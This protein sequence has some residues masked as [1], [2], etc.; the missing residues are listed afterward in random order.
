MS[1]ASASSPRIAVHSLPFRTDFRGTTNIRDNFV[2]AA[3]N[4]GVLVAH[5]RGRRLLGETVAVPPGY[6]GCVAVVPRT[7]AGMKRG[8]VEM[9]DEAL[10]DDGADAS[11]AD[12][13]SPGVGN[14]AAT[15][16]YSPSSTERRMASGPSVASV[17]VLDYFDSLVVWEHD[18]PPTGA[19]RAPLS[20]LRVAGVLHSQMTSESP[21]TGD[22]GKA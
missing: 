3:D 19:E 11:A 18:R 2:P 1:A 20:F 8:R 13:R 7:V 9:V 12:G 14:G 10:K 21:V 16:S 17:T 5:F 6:I 4:K 22:E 15:A